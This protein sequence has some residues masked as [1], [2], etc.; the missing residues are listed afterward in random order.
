MASMKYQQKSEKCPAKSKNPKIRYRIDSLA[1]EGVTTAAEY[2]KK[3]ED[4]LRFVDDDVYTFLAKQLDWRLEGV[5]S[6]DVK[7]AV[8]EVPDFFDNFSMRIQ[9]VKFHILV[10]IFSILSRAYKHGDI[11]WII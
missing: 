3:I 6:E 1:E 7:K 11:I 2:E 9:L 10:R 5:L 8:Q 4:V